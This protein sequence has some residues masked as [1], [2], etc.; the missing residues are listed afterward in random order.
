MAGTSPVM[1]DGAVRNNHF[2]FTFQADTCHPRESGDPA[3]GTELSGDVSR[4]SSRAAQSGKPC[5]VVV[6]WMLAFTSTTH[7]CEAPPIN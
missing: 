6:F 3:V 4:K 7:V 2:I 5:G 1:T